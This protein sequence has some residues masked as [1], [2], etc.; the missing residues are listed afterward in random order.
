MYPWVAAYHANDEDDQTVAGSSIAYCSGMMLKPW[1]WFPTFYFDHH[2]T[3][4]TVRAKLGID[5]SGILIS[6]IA[7]LIPIIVIVK[8]LTQ[9]QRIDRLTFLDPART[10]LFRFFS[11]APVQIGYAV[12]TLC[13]IVNAVIVFQLIPYVTPPAIAWCVW[14]VWHIALMYTQLTLLVHFALRLPTHKRNRAILLSGVT[15]GEEKG[16]MEEVMATAKG[17]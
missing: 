14:S 13:F 8:F 10:L 2:Y 16:E 15:A 4:H 1:Y 12:G 11:L 17:E 6:R 3:W 9:P 5:Y 7:A